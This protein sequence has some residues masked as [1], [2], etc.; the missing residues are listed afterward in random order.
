MQRVSVRDDGDVN[1]APVLVTLSTVDTV[2]NVLKDST[3]IA[4][5]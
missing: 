4:I 3:I 1:D 5:G 2:I